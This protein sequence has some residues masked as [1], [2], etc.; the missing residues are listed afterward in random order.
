VKVVSSLLELKGDMN[1]QISDA[2]LAKVKLQMA[3]LSSDFSSDLQFKQHPNVAKFAPTGD[4][5]VA[6]KDA[7]RSFPVGQPIALLKWR[8]S[9]KDETFVPLSINCWPTPSNDGTCDVNI[10]Y[11]LENER[12]TLQ[13]VVI[14]IPLPPGSYP[15]VSS[16][17]GEW[18]LNGSAHALDWSI[19]VISADERSGSLEFNVG[20]D[21]V[22]AFFPVKVSFVSQ[23]SLI[24]MAV[25]SVTRLEDG[26]DA[27][28]SQD[29]SLVTDEYLVI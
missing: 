20:G 26:T 8:Y 29:V 13:D 28:F 18:S 12:L 10:E 11:E 24:D 22:S 21:D 2:S 17:T 16:H 9:G 27:T 25:G 1:L 14:S 23:N 3:P 7:S 5:A 6:L 19:P 4:R 15:S